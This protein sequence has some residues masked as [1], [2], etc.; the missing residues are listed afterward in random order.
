MDTAQIWNNVLVYGVQIGLL[1]GIGAGL[2][3]LLRLRVAHARLLYWQFLLVAC[4][5]LPWFRPWQSEVVAV[6]PAAVTWLHPANVQI[7]PPVA[8]FVM[9]SFPTIALWLLAAGMAARLASLALGLLK[10]SRYRRRG[11][12]I[13]LP[14]EWRSTARPAR[15]LVSEEAAGPVTFGFFRPVVL[16]P[17]SFPAMPESMRN[18]ILFHELLHVERHDWLFTLGEE[19]LRAAFWFHP[20]VWWVLGEIQLSR[21]QTVDQAVIEMTQSRDPYVD[22]LLAMAGVHQPL[23]L[24]PAPLFLRRRHLRQ[25]VFGI[26][27]EARTK[28]SNT[29]VRLAQVAAVMTIALAGWFVTGAIPLHAQPQVVTDGPGVSVNLNGSQL[30]HRPAVMYPADALSKGVEG[31]IVAQVRLDSSGE[32]IDAAILSGPDELRR[33]VQQCVL[34]WHFDRSAGS[35]VRVVNID[36]VKPF[37]APSAGDNLNSAKAE[38]QSAND[39]LTAARQV[40]APAT[41]LEQLSS[42]QAAA[43]QTY[44][45]LL[46]QAQTAQ[47]GQALLQ[48][49]AAAPNDQA[50]E[51]QYEFLRSAVTQAQEQLATA[52]QQQASPLQIQSR[53]STVD[54]VYRRL[55]AFKEANAGTL[56]ESRIA[57][58]QQAVVGFVQD[59]LDKARYDLAQ[60]QQQHATPEQLRQNQSVV[61]DITRKLQLAQANSAQIQ[62]FAE[63]GIIERIEVTGLSDSAKAELLEQLPAHVGDPYSFEKLQPIQAA[64]TRFDSHL[65]VAVSGR[66]GAYTLNIRTQQPSAFTTPA[67]PGTLPAGAVRVGAVPVQMKDEGSPKG[68]RRSD[69]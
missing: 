31:T 37:A 43:D 25:R 12:A 66:P 45:N 47:A 13:P 20:A 58:Q 33:S 2:P 65:I 5:A 51:Q 24:S 63:S 35:A 22:A 11:H 9:P 26:V 46:R 39:S 41:Q 55:V 57:I 64:V 49:P 36:F 15:I 1:V 16:L 61:D 27:Q 10:L 34:T 50:L 53:Q 42:R 44:Q 54:D 21:E 60:S 62:R 67:T 4:L 38:L 48:R 30:L 28:M 40:Q 14:A 68:L 29:R 18:A 69:R 3:A 59:L 19:I 32:V 6:N 23:E 8:S 56:P 52:R 17:S 7:A